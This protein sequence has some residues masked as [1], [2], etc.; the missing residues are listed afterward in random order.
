MAGV[1]R[2]AGHLRLC[3]CDS[4]HG[5]LTWYD[6]LQQGDRLAAQNW[7]PSEDRSVFDLPKPAPLGAEWVRVLGGIPQTEEADNLQIANAL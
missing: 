1:P 4:S 2:D 3:R 6:L 5:L 7:I